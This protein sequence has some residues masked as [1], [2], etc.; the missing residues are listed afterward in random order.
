MK[1]KLQHPQWTH[2]PAAGL[3]IYLAVRWGLDGN[4]PGKVPYHF[5][6]NGRP[7]A[8]G[9]MPVVMAMILGISLLFLVISISG[10]EGW[11]RSEKK[12]AFNWLSLLDEIFLGLLVG[13]AVGYLT[14]LQAGETN[15]IFPWANVLIFSGAATV[16]AALLELVRPF[17][18]LPQALV[19]EDSVSMEKELQ[20]KLRG[21]QNFVYWQSQNP[22]WMNVVTIIVPVIMVVAAVVMFEE[23]PWFSLLY[24]ILAITF[25]LL[26]GGMRTTITRDN[27][28]VRLGLMSWRVLRIKTSEILAV[29][30]YEFSPL[31]D[32]GGYGVR[33]GKGM[34]AFYL[35]GG[36][37]VK[38]TLRNGMKYL[39][40]A[41]HPEQ[42]AVVVKAVS[43]Q[44]T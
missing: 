25:A 17:N 33:F 42:M 4:L 35:K 29:E 1:I 44:T 30:V 39:I 12:K 8:Y 34:F 15:I 16:L 38:L 20:L 26:N 36:R 41:D 6:F 11:A 10:D 19:T 14:Y 7:D 43:K 40:G 13:V 27:V 22:L 23:Q 5:A 3:I 31:K 24:L 2:I 21:Q 37:G 18:P 32:F 28:S 9:S